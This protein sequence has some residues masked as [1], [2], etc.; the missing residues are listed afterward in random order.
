MQCDW[1]DD[2]VVRVRRRRWE[3]LVYAVVYRCPGCRRKTKI[4]KHPAFYLLSL[5]RSCPKCG[6][7]QLERLRKRD[8]IDPLYLNPVSLL[9]RLL[10]ASIYWCS[11]CR[12][13]FYDMRPAWP[14]R[15][16]G[17]RGPTPTEDE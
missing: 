2:Y 1:C 13:Q 5:H 3:R 7:P 15:R 17:G 4:F 12:L 16:T 6:S 11:S 14:V 8:H 10:G 9:Q